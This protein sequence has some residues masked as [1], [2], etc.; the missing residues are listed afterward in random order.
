[1]FNFIL[2]LF[3]FILGTITNVSECS[4]SSIL[5]DPEFSHGK[6]QIADDTVFFISH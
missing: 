6:M 3:N 1:M 4:R 5:T 2:E